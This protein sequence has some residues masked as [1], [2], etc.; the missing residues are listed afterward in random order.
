MISELELTEEFGPGHGP[1]EAGGFDR[2][3]AVGRR[4]GRGLLWGVTGALA[5]SAVW[6][7]A[8]FAYGVGVDPKPDAHGY[9]VGEKSCA[10]MKLK[11]LTGSLGKLETAPTP[12]PGRIKHPAL[13][14]FGC[15]ATFPAT[16]IP[17]KRARNESIQVVVS[18]TAELHKE[19]DPRPEFEALSTAK[20][21]E[22]VEVA[23]VE[24]V[25][26][27][28]DRAYLWV[29]DGGVAYLRVVEGGAVVSLALSFTVA[30]DDYDADGDDPGP[31]ERTEAPDPVSYRADMI[32]GMRDVME[33]LKAD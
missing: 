30:Y 23:E 7:T 1:E 16:E 33:G 21:I 6:V 27:L 20:Y 3:R 4:R 5:A 17:G 24:S 13:D 19:T 14:R 22:G 26:H 9:R 31:E 11:A 25:P 15:T 29:M 8:V 18:V 28:G 12:E 32:S 10:G 2:P